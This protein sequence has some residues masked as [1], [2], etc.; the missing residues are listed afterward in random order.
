VWADTGAEK[1]E[2]GLKP[3][4]DTLHM[5]MLELKISTSRQIESSVLG[6]F[7]MISQHVHRGEGSDIGPVRLC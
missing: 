1:G 5:P 7:K 2:R 6:K 4:V 3:R